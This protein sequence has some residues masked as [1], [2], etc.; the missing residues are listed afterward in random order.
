MT[1]H[2]GLNFL[3]NWSIFESNFAVTGIATC[4][5]EVCVSFNVLNFD[6]FIN[7]YDVIILIERILDIFPQS[8]QITSLDFN[9]EHLNIF[10]IPSIDYGF[11]SYNLYYSNFINDDVILIH[12]TNNINETSLQIDNFELN[13]QN[14]F[15]IG[16]EDFTGCELI[17]QQYNYELPYKDYHLDQNGNILNTE[18]SVSDFKSSDQ[19]VECHEDHYNEW[20]SSMHSYTARSPLFFSYKNQVN[21]NHPNIGEKFCMQCHNPVSF[22]IES[23]PPV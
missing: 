15:W 1:I 7:I 20:F 21:N 13:E 12:T 11:V 14:Y 2:S 8:T 17:S 23:I 19:C 18:F 10:W 6:S 5:K 3:Y 9:F 16:V 4:K 22:L